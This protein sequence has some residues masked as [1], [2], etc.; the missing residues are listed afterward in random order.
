MLNNKN[1]CTLYVV[2]HGE[3][4]WNVRR[5]I[6]GHTDIDLNAQGEEQASTLSTELKDINFSAVYSSDL[7]RAKR[8]AEIIV[9]EN[10]LAVNTTKLLRE[11]S[12]GHFEGQPG[13]TYSEIEDVLSKLTDEE[14]FSSNH[15]PDVEND[16]D[17]INRFLTFA[18]EVCVVNAGKNILITTHGGMLRTL[19]IHLGYATYKDNPKV[20]NA[21]YIV[22]KS[23][24]ID[25]FIIDTKGIEKRS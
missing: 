7:L 17:L 25:F 6:Q 16:E 1:Y 18:R 10:K 11:R 4:D 22:L 23:D 9:L 20:A 5:L 21:A 14:R 15:F 24:G 2:R 12:F 3:T 19:L 8:T 13:E